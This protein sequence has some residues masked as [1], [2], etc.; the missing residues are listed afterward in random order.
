MKIE[1]GKVASN[2]CNMPLEHTAPQWTSLLWFVPPV[3][4]EWACRHGLAVGCNILKWIEG[5]HIEIILAQRSNGAPLSSCSLWHF[6]AVN[7]CLHGLVHVLMC[8]FDWFWQSNDV[9][10][11]VFS[12]SCLS[13]FIICRSVHHYFDFLWIAYQLDVAEVKQPIPWYLRR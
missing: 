11:I 5:F 1:W 10:P 4:T 12:P 13:K 8:R 3:F 9:S 6:G 7:L 2:A